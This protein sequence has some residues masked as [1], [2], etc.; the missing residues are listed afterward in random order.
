MPMI[1]ARF[2]TQV[3][4]CLLHND[5]LENELT[6]EMENGRLFRLLTKLGVIN[7]RPQF[8]LDPAWAETGDRYLLKLFRDYLFHQVTGSGAPW[9][10]LSHI[11]QTLNKLDARSPERICLV[12]RDEQSV[13]VVSYEHL[14]NCLSS[15]FSELQQA[16]N[17][18]VPFAP[19]L[20]S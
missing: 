12:S 16:C 3:E 6:K 20:S 2:Y 11:I 17:S 19:E 18:D 14:N 9:L 15:V 4:N 5:L 1:G 13:M 8:G 7:E 10:D